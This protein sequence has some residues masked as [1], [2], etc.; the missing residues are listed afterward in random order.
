MS[1]YPGEPDEYSS[2][3]HAVSVVA[4]TGR[5]IAELIQDELD[6]WPVNLTETQVSDI[7]E[8]AEKFVTDAVEKAWNEH[9]TKLLS[10]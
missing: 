1:L 7:A 3:D 9:A 5:R 2:Y 8:Q 6:G 10:E 4:R